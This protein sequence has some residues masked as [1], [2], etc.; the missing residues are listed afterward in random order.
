MSRGRIAAL[1]ALAGFLALGVAAPQTTTPRSDAARRAF[2]RQ[3]GYPNGRPGYV[4]DHVVPLA[5]GGAD[6]PANMQWQTVQAAKAK[7]R[8]ER[9]DCSRNATPAPRGAAKQVQ[10]KPKPAPSDADVTVYVTK[11]G[12]K[13]HR[14]GCSSLRKSAIPMKLK[15]AV[16]AG[17]E[18][19]KRCKPPTLK[20]P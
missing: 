15:D 20:E 9:I 13:Y 16:A 18:P 5:C 6:A 3:T 14:A 10:A 1:A 4:V 19:C 2:M 8:V 17:Y 7:D 12:E 11:T